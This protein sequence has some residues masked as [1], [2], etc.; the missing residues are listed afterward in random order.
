MT[1]VQVPKGQSIYAVIDASRRTQQE[2][3]RRKT[4]DWRKI[5]PAAGAGA[6]VAS[7]LISAHWRPKG[8]SY[9]AELLHGRATAI[10]IGVGLA[11]GFAAWAGVDTL[12]HGA[13]SPISPDE[14]FRPGTVVAERNAESEQLAIGKLQDHI[15]PTAKAAAEAGI[16]EGGN[17]ILVDTRFAFGWYQFADSPD[18]RMGQTRDSRV[19]AGWVLYNLDGPANDPTTWTSVTPHAQDPQLGWL[20]GQPGY[21][22]LGNNL[23]QDGADW[24]GGG[25]VH[26]NINDL[27]AT[28]HGTY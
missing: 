15:Y 3:V 20:G 6:A 21:L 27:E 1:A 13:D 10:G 14:Q 17:H 24:S 12:I 28:D 23:Y 26:A 16:A 7:G 5:A 25:F 22:Q 11:A 19:P 4:S 18:S 9:V 8:V 2:S